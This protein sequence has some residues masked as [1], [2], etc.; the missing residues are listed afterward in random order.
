MKNLEDFFRTVPASVCP[1]HAEDCTAAHKHH[2]E[3]MIFVEVQSTT[4]SHGRPLKAA[5]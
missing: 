1:V 4:D 2:Y 5:K 3:P